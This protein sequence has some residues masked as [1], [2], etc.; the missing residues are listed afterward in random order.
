M[1]ER[2]EIRASVWGGSGLQAR[3]QR[4]AKIVENF[5]VLNLNSQVHMETIDSRLNQNDLVGKAV[6]HIGSGRVGFAEGGTLYV[7]SIAWIPRIIWPSKPNIGGSGGLVSRFTGQ[8]FAEGTSVGVGQVLEFYVNWG[9]TS[10]LIGFFLYGC[11]LQYLDQRAGEGLLQGD[12][13]A[14]V[15]WALPALGLMQAGGSMAETV[16][17]VA[18]GFVFIFLM[19]KFIFA[20]YYEQGPGAAPLQRGSRQSHRG[21]KYPQSLG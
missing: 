15:R 16:G 14:A 10:V 6:H 13:W 8:K 17:S 19:H 7:A 18:A 3:L 2:V 1:R 9:L 12:L 21:S 11:V 5:E 20:K 4:M